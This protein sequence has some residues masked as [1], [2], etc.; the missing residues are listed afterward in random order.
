[1]DYPPI[2]QFC[3]NFLQRSKTYLKQRPPSAS[4]ANRGFLLSS[5]PESVVRLVNTHYMVLLLTGLLQFKVFSPQCH[6]LF[7]LLLAL[8]TCS[9]QY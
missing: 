4:I 5:K 3:L 2:S 9:A 7:A 6:T 1:M 8:R